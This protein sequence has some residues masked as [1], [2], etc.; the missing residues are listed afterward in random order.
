MTAVRR[1]SLWG[2]EKEKKAYGWHPNDGR[3]EERLVQSQSW[4]PLLK[5]SV[6]AQLTPLS[7]AATH[8]WLWL[9]VAASSI[10]SKIYLETPASCNMYFHLRFPAC[11]QEKDFLLEKEPKCNNEKQVLCDTFY[12]TSFKV[13]KYQ[14]PDEFKHNTFSHPG[15]VLA[16]VGKVVGHIPGCRWW[17]CTHSRAHP[18]ALL[19]VPKQQLCLLQHLKKGMK[20]FLLSASAHWKSEGVLRSYREDRMGVSHLFTCRVVS[21]NGT[22]VWSSPWLLVTHPCKAVAGTPWSGR[23][24]TENIY[25]DSKMALLPVPVLSAYWMSLT[26]Q[27]QGQPAQVASSNTNT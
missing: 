27:S 11:T 19:A 24:S 12:N 14:R 22:Q 8:Q 15:Q 26:P 23:A 7:S 20:S 13:C 21:H 6:L 25:V 10:R 1:K 17:L 18:A 3:S 9:V 4:Q 16:T 2:W 5:F